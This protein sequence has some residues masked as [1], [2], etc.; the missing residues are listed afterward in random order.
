M[1]LI[2]TSAK[3]LSETIRSAIRSEI[4]AIN[5]NK[6]VGS[7]DGP[8]GDLLKRSD[9]AKMF[10]ISLV[11]VHSWMNSGILPFH[12]IGGRTFFKK[13]E[14]LESLKTIKIRRKF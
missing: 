8:D 3:E 12:R 10:N 11:T 13:K 7:I 5:L 9:V 2:I 4:N 6:Q 14:V 1:E